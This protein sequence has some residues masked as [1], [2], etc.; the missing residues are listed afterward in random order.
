[1][2]ADFVH[3]FIVACGV[4]HLHAIQV[5]YMYMSSLERIH[6]VLFAARKNLLSTV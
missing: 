3:V 1:V 5:T 6:T 2:T 4:E